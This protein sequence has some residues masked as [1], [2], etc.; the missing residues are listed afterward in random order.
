MYVVGM[1]YRIPFWYLT[2]GLYVSN[3]ILVCI[4]VC[5][6]FLA[7]GMKI[8]GRQWEGWRRPIGP[9]HHSFHLTR[10]SMQLCVCG[11]IHFRP[12]CPQQV[13]TGGIIQGP[14]RLQKPRIQ[15][16][17]G[18]EGIF[19]SLIT[20]LTPNALTTHSRLIASSLYRGC[21]YALMISFLESIRPLQLDSYLIFLF[22]SYFCALCAQI[23]PTYA[24]SSIFIFIGNVCL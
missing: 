9:K 18:R 20:T 21:L 14:G 3:S 22:L 6:Y 13:K 23:H 24:D 2:F 17:L 11:R 5:T 7:Q 8:I 12:T 10:S 4:L 19:S 15:I 16:V 1:Y